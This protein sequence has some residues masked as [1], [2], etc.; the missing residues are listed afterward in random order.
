MVGTDCGVAR[1]PCML[2]FAGRN[3][4]MARSYSLLS[5]LSWV[6]AP[7]ARFDALQVDLKH[8]D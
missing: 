5:P 8:G 4:V 6:L 1:D 7:E 2:D 3:P